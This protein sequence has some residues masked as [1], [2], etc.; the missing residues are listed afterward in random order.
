MTVYRINKTY[1]ISLKLIPVLL[2]TICGILNNCSSDSTNWRAACKQFPVAVKYK[3]MRFFC[4]FSAQEVVLAILWMR[5]RLRQQSCPF[6]PKAS[7]RLILLSVPIS[8][9][10]IIIISLHYSCL[11]KKTENTHFAYP[12]ARSNSLYSLSVTGSNQ[13]TGPFETCV[14]MATCVNSL[15]G[16]APCQC[17]ILGAILTT[18]PG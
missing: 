15:S 11:P 10:Y 4:G 8:F 3:M 12:S 5:R 17:T 1:F 14:P 16:A 18:S 9:N 7:L 6:V 2:F 13:S